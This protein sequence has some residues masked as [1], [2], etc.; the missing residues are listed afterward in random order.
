MRSRSITFIIR[1][2]KQGIWFVEFQY[3][4]SPEGLENRSLCKLSNGLFQCALKLDR[5][6]GGDGSKNMEINFVIAV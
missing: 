6:L 4:C 1:L 2:A 3:L 5:W